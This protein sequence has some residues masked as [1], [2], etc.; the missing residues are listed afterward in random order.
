MAAHRASAGDAPVQK[1][2]KRPTTDMM[3]RNAPKYSSIVITEL[4]KMMIADT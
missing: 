3:I 2:K 1:A 4:K